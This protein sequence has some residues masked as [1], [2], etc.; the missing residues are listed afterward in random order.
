MYK[1][2]LGKQRSRGIR[3][4]KEHVVDVQMKRD[5]TAMAQLSYDG[6]EDKVCLT[7]QHA[8]KKLLYSCFVAYNSDVE[9][10]VLSKCRYG[11]LLSGGKV[12][13]PWSDQCFMH[14]M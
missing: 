10:V 3:H 12:L 5:Q 4:N 6:T 11:R 8:N 1:Q 2:L 9:G 13:C 7:H 14:L